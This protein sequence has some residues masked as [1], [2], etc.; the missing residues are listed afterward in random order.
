MTNEERHKGL[1][2]IANTPI[3][4]LYAYTVAAQQI[5]A[6]IESARKVYGGL[7]T[8]TQ[9]TE[10]AAQASSNL[11]GNEIF[12]LAQFLNRFLFAGPLVDGGRTA[13]RKDVTIAELA[14]LKRAADFLQINF[15]ISA[16]ALG[17]MR[18]FTGRAAG[19]AD[20]W[21]MTPA[22]MEKELAAIAPQAG[23]VDDFK[24]MVQEQFAALGGKIDAQQAKVNET[25]AAANLAAKNSAEAK[26]AAEQIAQ[27]TAGLPAAIAEVKA[28][29]AG[30]KVAAEG[31][32][33]AAEKGAKKPTTVINAQPGATVNVVKPPRTDAGGTHGKTARGW[34]TQADVA[35]DFSKQTKK[36]GGRWY[37][38]VTEATVKDWENRYPNEAR[39]E[40]KSGYHAGLRNEPNPTPETKKA[41][42]AAAA[43]WNDYWRK[44]NEAFN[45]WLK[46]N[47]NGDHATFLKTWKRPGKT[48]HRND[49]DKTMRYGADTS[50]PD[51]LDSGDFD[52]E[53]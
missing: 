42:Y 47:L 44:H 19:A 8:E 17:M 49:T 34:R 32:R 29:A 27:T 53:T 6:M 50:L 2:E 40:R 13:L 20:F 30:A 12:L 39:R 46:A 28:E 36:I 41:Y 43:N 38:K 37:G 4:D 45:A 18:I 11:T 51:A 48:V 15:Q 52:N 25:Q 5:N 35:A 10:F 31:A 23:M 7:S 1:L 33:T 21:G 3:C 9:F 14:Y 24:K 16:T 26:R 22:D